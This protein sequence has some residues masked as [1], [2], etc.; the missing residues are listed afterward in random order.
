MISSLKKNCTDFMEAKMTKDNALIALKQGL[1][2]ENKAVVEKCFDLIRQNPAYV[3]RPHSFVDLDL[4][5]VKEILKLERL[6]VKKI[7]L[8]LAVDK[9]CDNQL[10]RE[11]ERDNPMSKREILGDALYLIRFPAMSLSDFGKHCVLSQLLTPE[12][13]NYLVH[14]L[15]LDPKERRDAV[16]KVISAFKWPGNR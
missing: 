6:N 5:S 2:F 15:S 14:Y 4:R 7:D 3:L 11:M 8:F 1:L 10:I 12:E 13:N 9:W 16:T